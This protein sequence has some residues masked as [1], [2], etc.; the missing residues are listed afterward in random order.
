[1]SSADARRR[2][3]LQQELSVAVSHGPRDVVLAFDFASHLEEVADHPQ[4]AEFI[5]GLARFARVLLFDM[6]GI[7]MSG[8]VAFGRAEVESWMEEV[9][10]VMEAEG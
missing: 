7:G 4:M 6:R 9:V 5:G 3:R 2:A 1:M 8:G 10:A